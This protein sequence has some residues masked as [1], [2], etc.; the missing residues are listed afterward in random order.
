MPR[1][2]I[3]ATLG[4]A[5]DSQTILRKMVFCGLDVVRLNFSHGTQ[6]DHL[7]RLRL[8]REINKKY[9]RAIKIMQD[10]EGYRIRIGRFSKER[11]L[12]KGEIL[13]LTQNEPVNP[14]R[15]I[16]WDYTGSLKAIKRGYFIYIDD[17]RI[18]LKV[19]ARERKRLACRVVRGGVL[20]ER[21]GINIPQARLDFGSLSEKDKE[22]IG[23]A[24]RYKLDYIAQS[25]VRRS[26]DIILL[27]K[28]LLEKR[29][30]QAKVFAKIESKEALENIDEIIRV[31]DGIMIARGDLGICLPIYKVGIIQKELIKKC[32]LVKKPV[33]VATQMLESMKEELL[34]LRAE[35]SDVTTAVLDGADFVML[36]AETAV[37]KHPEKVVEMMNKII[38]CAE[39]YQRLQ[40]G[41]F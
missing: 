35:V 28:I 21:K 11:E 24:I 16:P 25:F 29:H 30:P 2:K 6:K 23:F 39:E 4:P 41:Y 32:R 27:K 36:S 8:V 15:E 9:G 10:L 40:K 5:T 18:V 20:K 22:D 34:P 38:K 26:Q 14:E 12:K 19:V 1:V 31:A 7:W 33:I 3:I 17:A 13:Y 37:G